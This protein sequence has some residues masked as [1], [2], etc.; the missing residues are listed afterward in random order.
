M[1]VVV[2]VA[3]F[4]K[5]DYNWNEWHHKTNS[6]MAAASSSLTHNNLDLVLP[7]GH[8]SKD[9]KAIWLLSGILGLLE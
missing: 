9:G 8:K 3:F 6:T 1:V 5:P 4:K 2:V 7:I